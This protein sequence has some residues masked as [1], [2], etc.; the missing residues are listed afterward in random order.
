[1]DVGVSGFLES[2][3]KFDNDIFYIFV[4]IRSSSRQFRLLWGGIGQGHFVND[5]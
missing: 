5:E 1:M 4:Q 3:A 2:G